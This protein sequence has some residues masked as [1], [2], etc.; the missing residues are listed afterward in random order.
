LNSACYAIRAVNAMLSKK[1]LRTLY[2]SDVHSIISYGITV[3]GNIPNSINIFS[4]QN[5]S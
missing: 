2:F 5:K 1:A 4:M 3:W